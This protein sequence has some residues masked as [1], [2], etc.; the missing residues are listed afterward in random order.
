MLGLGRR[1]G[2]VPG[3]REVSRAPIVDG[4]L[5]RNKG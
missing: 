5:R 4:M 1:I 2:V 3:A